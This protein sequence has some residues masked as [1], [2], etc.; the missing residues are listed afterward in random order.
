MDVKEV[1]KEYITQ[2]LLYHDSQITL[3]EEDILLEPGRLDSLGMLQVV[4][5]LES[6][7]NVHIPQEDV[8][9]EAFGSIKTIADY[10]EKLKGQS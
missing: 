1:L 7:F 4:H 6:H 9:V 5:F 10:L 2:V 3:Q 8:T